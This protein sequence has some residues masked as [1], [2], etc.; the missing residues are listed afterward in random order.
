VNEHTTGDTAVVGGAE[1]DHTC[2]VVTPAAKVSGEPVTR[3]APVQLTP[4]VQPLRN[5]AA[6]GAKLT[7]PL[8]SDTA[9]V[10]GSATTV[11]ADGATTVSTLLAGV[12]K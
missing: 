7:L 4:S 12:E 11:K 2:G 8:P 10:L 5:G 6:T 9:S 3:P 1:Y